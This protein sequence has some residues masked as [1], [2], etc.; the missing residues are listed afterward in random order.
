MQIEFTPADVVL[1][2]PPLTGTL[3][4][5][6]LEVAAGVMVLILQELGRG[7]GMVTWQDIQEAIKRAQ[8]DQK[9][10]LW[11][12]FTNPFLRPDWEG[13]VDRGLATGV[14]GHLRAL[15]LTPAAIERL[16]PWVRR[17]GAHAAS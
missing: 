14:D 10:T 17:T 11:S 7:W 4:K 1:T 12:W 6:E 8:T 16:R 5:T 9:G 3:G 2:T 15:E 13:L